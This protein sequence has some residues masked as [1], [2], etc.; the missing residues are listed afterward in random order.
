VRLF[1]ALNFPPSLR[2]DLWQA[3][4]PLRARA[5]PVR[6]VPVDAMHLTVKF[7]GDVSADRVPAINAALAQTA[8]GAR[9]V[10]LEVTGFGVFPN[11]EAPRVV[12]VG[13]VPDPALELLHHDAER[14]FAPLGFPPEG[15][16]FLPHV[17][18][19]RA[20][21]TARP[22][23]FV[24]LSDVLVGLSYEGTVRVESVELMES[25]AGPGGV[26]YHVRLSERL[27]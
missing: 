8:A 9:A 7:L 3:A 16:P 19:G 26:T 6:W 2:H 14:V 21:R 25:R 20:T 1:V 22:R 24:G 11:A 27:L 15:R 4:A 12:W 13:L 23:D 17:T 10:V 5:F 18:L